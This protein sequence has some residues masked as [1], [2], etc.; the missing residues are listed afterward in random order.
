MAQE[1]SYPAIL[2]DEEISASKSYLY[3]KATSKVEEFVK[4]NEYQKISF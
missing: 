4:E 2:S 3:K 1:T